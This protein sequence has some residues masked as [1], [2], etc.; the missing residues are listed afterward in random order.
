MKTEPQ[1]STE[2]L[3][4]LR[5]AIANVLIFFDAIN[6]RMPPAD[7]KCLVDYLL[8]YSGKQPEPPLVKLGQG[9]YEKDYPVRK[10]K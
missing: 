6:R 7:E 8:K 1:F 10:T 3:L 5:S 2:E 9:N 4:R